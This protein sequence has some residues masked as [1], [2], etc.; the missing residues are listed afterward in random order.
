M[1]T[2]V[3]ESLKL[4]KGGEEG[5]QKLGRPACS[6]SVSSQT[7]DARGRTGVCLY[8]CFLGRGGRKGARREEEEVLGVSG[9]S[10]SSNLGSTISFLVFSYVMT[11]F[12]ITP[13]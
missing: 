13:R 6:I 2:E 1:K 4:E 9:S 11:K 5:S 10:Y 8:A 12:P 7:G 3:V